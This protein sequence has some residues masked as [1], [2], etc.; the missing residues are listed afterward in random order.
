MNIAALI[1]L[2]NLTQVHQGT[3]GARAAAGVLLG[4]YNGSR[5]PFDLTDLRVLDEQHFEA[6]MAVIRCDGT[7]CHLE[8]HSW[9]NRLT[10]RHDFGQRFEHLAHEWRRKGKCKRDYLDP[11]LPAHLVIDEPPATPAAAPAAQGE[12]RSD[13]A[14]TSESAS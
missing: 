9:L 13:F 11:V 14:E 7:R 8:V 5:F 2:W 1:K 10:G 3:S 6:A 12:P 4:L